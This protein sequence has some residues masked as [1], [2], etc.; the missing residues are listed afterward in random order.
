MRAWSLQAL[1]IEVNGVLAAA[2]DGLAI[3]DEVLL[4]VSAQ[5]DSEI[6]LVD[7]T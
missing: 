4:R 5:E 6:V 1:R 7:V 2:G 3:D